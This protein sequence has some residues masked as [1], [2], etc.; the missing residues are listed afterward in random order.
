MYIRDSQLSVRSNDDNVTMGDLNTDQLIAVVDQQRR[1]YD[2]VSAGN[3]SDIPP[4]R[5]RTETQ[6]HDDFDSS[7]NWRRNQ[8]NIDAIDGCPEI[9]VPE[10]A[11]GVTDSHHQ[12]AYVLHLASTVILALLVLEVRY[13]SSVSLFY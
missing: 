7:T 11:G 2:S 13:C 3:C 4:K 10:K 12:V 6:F 1:W 5:Q 9:T 8:T